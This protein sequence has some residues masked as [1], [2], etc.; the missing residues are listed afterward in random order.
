VA[1]FKK[2]PI[3]DI[4]RGWK[5]LMRRLAT[6][7]TEI[8]V[9]V[10]SQD[11]DVPKKLAEGED[12]EG[13]TLLEVAAAHEF[14][15]GVPRRSFIA[16]WQDENRERHKQQVA[17]MAKSI[18]AG[19]MTAKVAAERLGNLWVGE[20]QKRIA[21]GI[22]PELSEQRKKEKKSSVPLID[23][24]QLRSSIAYAV[25]GK[26]SPSKAYTEQVNAPA[27]A[28]AKAQKEAERE[29]KKK[30]AAIKK[31]AKQS[32]RNASTLLKKDL[33]KASK[34]TAKGLKKASKKAA[35]TIER[36]ARKA[37]AATARNAKKVAKRLSRN[38]SRTAKKNSRVVK[39]KLKRTRAKKKPPQE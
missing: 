3:R 34:S 23:T 27:I 22:K 17:V 36:G 18:A 7:N 28:A 38:A 5:D 14:G 10:H 21:A 12:D 37:A 15:I 24:G 20:V 6:T 11:G 30:V 25:N 31:A 16:D 32:L 26:L 19:K 9:G 8:T 1:A 2:A 29:R 33:K 4:D 35:K 39:K 13:L